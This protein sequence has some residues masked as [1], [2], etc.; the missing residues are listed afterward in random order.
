MTQPDCLP[1]IWNVFSACH[2]NISHVN[3]NFWGRPTIS[4]PVG[5]PEKYNDISKFY[6]PDFACLRVPSRLELELL[7]PR[8][9]T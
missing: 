6:V 7:P 2:E 9:I 1:P 4:H 5:T 8:G 3:K